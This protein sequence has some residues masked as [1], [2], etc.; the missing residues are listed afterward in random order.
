[1]PTFDFSNI[2]RKI[3]QAAVSAVSNPFIII[4]AITVAIYGLI[5]SFTS[6]TSVFQFPEIHAE[7]LPFD[8]WDSNAFRD[9]ILYVFDFQNLY[10]F[11]NIIR[12][13]TQELINFM[14]GFTISC[15]GAI[16]IWMGYNGIRRA[17]KDYT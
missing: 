8:N 12:I 16:S 9:I 7:E 5:D 15:I 4:A 13:A 2:I 10:Y 17:L 6:L 11:Y 14:I 3:V 1:M